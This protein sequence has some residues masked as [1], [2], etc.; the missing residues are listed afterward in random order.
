MM[1]DRVPLSELKGLMPWIRQYT[2]DGEEENSIS[3]SLNTRIISVA[4]LMQTGLLDL[5]L[6]PEDALVARKI[7]EQQ[8]YYEEILAPRGDYDPPAVAA[9]HLLDAMLQVSK[10][11]SNSAG[12]T[13]LQMLQPVLSQREHFEK[14]LEICHHIQDHEVQFETVMALLPDIPE[15]LLPGF[16][17]L[18]FRAQNKEDAKENL[19]RLAARVGG[20]S[21]KTRWE[22]WRVIIGILAGM[23]RFQLAQNLTGILDLVTVMGGKDAI[24]FTGQAALHVIRWW[25]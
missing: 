15:D 20:L 8:P 25:A 6:R 18:V 12:G 3:T 14:A 7:L 10:D 16:I 13:F 21:F 9:G 5:C 19:V 11:D 2:Q 24:F 4:P 1:I 23:P 22:C 17:R